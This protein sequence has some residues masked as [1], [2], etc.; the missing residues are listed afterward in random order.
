MKLMDVDSLMREVV[1]HIIPEEIANASVDSKATLE[2]GR[3][4]AHELQSVGNNWPET[5]EQSMTEI[6]ENISRSHRHS[7]SAEANLLS[8]PGSVE[9]KVKLF[10]VLAEVRGGSP[11][12]ADSPESST[13]SKERH[14]AEGDS[15]VSTEDS[16]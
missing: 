11:D 14:E 13:A 3:S 15:L 5:G 12:R 1:S 9:E 8:V 16:F 4:P 7:L 10:T 2:N 6:V